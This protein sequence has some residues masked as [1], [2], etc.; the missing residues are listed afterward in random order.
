MKT[1]K[2]LGA[3][4]GTIALGT[5]AEIALQLMK[6]PAPDSGTGRQGRVR[7]CGKERKWNLKTG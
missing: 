7:L 1:V 6:K 2:I 4:L 5:A 3:A